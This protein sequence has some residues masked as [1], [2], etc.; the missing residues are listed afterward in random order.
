M[1]VL[2]IGGMLNDAA[3]VLLNDGELLAAVEQK[4][5]ARRH[6]PGDIPEEAIA[7]C[8]KIAQARL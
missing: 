4:K 7:A 3:A 1:I 2:G 6:R 8:L 5:I